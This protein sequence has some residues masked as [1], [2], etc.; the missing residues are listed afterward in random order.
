MS[1]R[2]ANLR[3]RIMGDGAFE[4]KIRRLAQHAR[5]HGHII[6]APSTLS[7]WPAVGGIF[8]SVVLLYS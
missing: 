1:Y 5:N 3:V 7:V 6:S 8:V 2:F 4:L